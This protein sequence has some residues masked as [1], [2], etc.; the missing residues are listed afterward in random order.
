[1]IE[2]I[3]Q[4][5]KSK[6]N[7][8]ITSKTALTEEQSSSS[9]KFLSDIIFR[10]AQQMLDQGNL[11][12]LK[13]MFDTASDDEKKAFVEEKKAVF[14]TELSDSEGISKEEGE[15]VATVA[16]PIFMKVAQD[17]LLDGRQP[18]LMDIPKILAFIKSGGTSTSG[19]GGLFGL[20][21]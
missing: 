6:A 7:P 21:G 17:K 13:N 8:N 12:E 19:G 20:F 9:I 1:M 4:E 2:E 10:E 18:G 3:L 5:V 11:M 14:L 16:L 15:V